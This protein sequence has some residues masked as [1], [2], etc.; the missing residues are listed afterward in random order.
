MRS[1][2]SD[3]SSDARPVA[4]RPSIRAA[5]AVSC[6]LPSST[7]T[8]ASRRASNATS[9]TIFVGP[10]RPEQRR[11]ARRPAPRA[12]RPPRRAR[13]VRHASCTVQMRARYVNMPLA[14]RSTAR[15]TACR[16]SPTSSAQV[17]F[18]IDDLH[19]R[20]RGVD[21]DGHAGSPDAISIYGASA[22]HRRAER[23]T[24]SAACRRPIANARRAR[25][26]SCAPGAADEAR[27]DVAPLRRRR[28][29][30]GREAV[31]RRGIA[32]VLRHEAAAV[33]RG[34]RGRRRAR[35]PAGRWSRGPP[36]RRR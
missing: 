22:S 28:S 21:S 31:A 2:S 7:P 34:R 29:R 20:V 33:R 14:S 11:R 15:R 32:R 1:P 4:A 16:A 24:P 23:R 17:G 30:T 27:R 35:R 19:Q 10:G 36:R 18:P 6:T 26:A 3:S 25:A 13:A 12:R 8:S 5:M 9:W